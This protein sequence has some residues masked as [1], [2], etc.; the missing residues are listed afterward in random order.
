M[1]LKNTGFVLFFVS[2]CISK[3]LANL[4]GSELGD[5]LGA[6]RDGVLGELSGE[7]E[8]DG[9]LNLPGGD[10][11]LL[12]IEGKTSSLSGHLVEDVV[13][14][15]VHDTHG[16]GADASVGVDLLEHLVDIDLVGLSLQ[17]REREECISMARLK[18]MQ[19]IRLTLAI[20]FLSLRSVVRA[21]NGESTSLRV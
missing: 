7:D 6:L 14:E 5:S 13:D 8:P 17:V 15:G 9:G 1:V 10:S 21:C 12:V 18:G 11:G 19:A 16:L 4:E 3:M 20:F 2:F